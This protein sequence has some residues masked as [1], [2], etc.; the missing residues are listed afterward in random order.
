MGGRGPAAGEETVTVLLPFEWDRT[1]FAAD[2]AAAT[3]RADTVATTAHFVIRT[4]CLIERW[5]RRASSDD[6]CGGERARA[7]RLRAPSAG[8]DDG[9]LA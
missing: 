6:G 5:S 4:R 1:T 9:R 8:A 2:T 7:K 3:A